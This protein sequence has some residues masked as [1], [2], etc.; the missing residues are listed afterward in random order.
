MLIQP[1]C[2]PY[3]PRIQRNTTCKISPPR[4][5]G[6][7]LEKYPNSHRSSI[8]LPTRN[9]TGADGLSS[10]IQQDHVKYGTRKKSPSRFLWN[11]IFFISIK[12]K[13]ILTP[14]HNLDFRQSHMQKSNHTDQKKKKNDTSPKYYISEKRLRGVGGH[15]THGYIIYSTRINKKVTDEI[16]IIKTLSLES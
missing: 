1:V 5:C 10:T 2:T 7:V 12:N 3:I 11:C 4:K 8:G 16:H 14:F 6:V 15:M 9:L 13:F